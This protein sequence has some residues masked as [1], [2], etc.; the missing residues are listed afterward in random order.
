MIGM[1]KRTTR[2]IRR[3]K[4]ISNSKKSFGRNLPFVVW[5]RIAGDM[6]NQGKTIIIAQIARTTLL[7][8]ACL[9]A[10]SFNIQKKK[11][12]CTCILYI[13]GK[14]RK[15]ALWLCCTNS[16]IWHRKFYER[17]MEGGKCCGRVKSIKYNQNCQKL[18]DFLR[19]YTLLLNSSRKRDFFL[20]A[21]QYSGGNEFSLSYTG[22]IHLFIYL[23]FD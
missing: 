13:R 17:E 23:Y 16:I 1:E 20:D 11:K 12:L 8:N 19:V 22:K 3:G 5:H 21:V 10:L 7:N 4:S 6:N 14:L 15:I 18:F 2:V 9:Y